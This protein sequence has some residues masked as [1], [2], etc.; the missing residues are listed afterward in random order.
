MQDLH[1]RES[2]IKKDLEDAR[3]PQG[4]ETLVPTIT[5]AGFNH[6]PYTEP[7]Y[8]K[9][10]KPRPSILEKSTTV[11]ITIEDDPLEDFERLSESLR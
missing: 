1:D 7:I 3:K 11:S 5:A 4:E 10:K 8:K 6:I 2:K 9:T